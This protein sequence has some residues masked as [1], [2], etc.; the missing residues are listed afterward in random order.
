[1]PD[2][3]KIEGVSTLTISDG[4]DTHTWTGWQTVD[5]KKSLDL[6]DVYTRVAK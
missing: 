3:K 6:H 5:G 2:G 1:M 4:G